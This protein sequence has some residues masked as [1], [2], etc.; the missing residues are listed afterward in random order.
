[1]VRPETI[2]GVE[3]YSSGGMIPPQYDRSSSTQCG[4]IV[5]WTR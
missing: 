2:K 4:S 5:I 3:V 1:M